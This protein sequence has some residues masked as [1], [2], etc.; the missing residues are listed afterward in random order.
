[1]T[2]IVFYARVCICKSLLT[3]GAHFHRQRRFISLQKEGRRIVANN[4]NNSTNVCVKISSTVA[5]SVCGPKSYKSCVFFAQ[6][7]F[8]S[9]KMN[10]FFS[11]T[12]TQFSLPFCVCVNA[13]CGRFPWMLKMYKT[14]NDNDLFLAIYKNFFLFGDS[15]TLFVHNGVWTFTG[16]AYR[17]SAVGQNSVA[18]VYTMYFAR[19]VSKAVSLKCRKLVASCF[20]SIIHLFTIFI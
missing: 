8:A 13:F 16:C 9:P 3:I 2:L 5:G 7:F 4:N 1:M 11:L 15:D 10:S 17:Q 12:R 19:H 14:L 18:S 6:H 20:Y